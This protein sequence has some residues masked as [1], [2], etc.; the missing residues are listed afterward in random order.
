MLKG[1]WKYIS[2]SKIRFVILVFFLFC[3]CFN[4]D[5]TWTCSEQQE[6]IRQQR[7]SAEVNSR[8]LPAE[9]NAAANAA[10]N[11]QGFASAAAKKLCVDAKARAQAAK[12]TVADADKAQML[13]INKQAIVNAKST[14]VLSVGTGENAEPACADG[15]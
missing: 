15:Q 4:K 6:Q 5:G 11:E 12:K 2:R 3:A 1:I 7:I 13:E 14:T 9:T 10:Y 8:G